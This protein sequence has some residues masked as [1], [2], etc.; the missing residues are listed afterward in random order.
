[1]NRKLYISYGSNMDRAQ[2]AVRCPDAKVV[3][4]G[5]LHNWRLFFRRYANIEPAEGKNTPV[6]VWEISGSDERRLDLYE[7][8][9]NF[10]I[11]KELE[12]ETFPAEGGMKKL[13]AMVYVMNGGYPA[14]APSS[15]YYKVL[16]D[17]YSAF[18]LPGHILR[19]ALADSIGKPQATHFLEKHGFQKAESR[20]VEPDD[21][22]SIL[23]LDS[24]FYIGMNEDGEEEVVICRQKGH[25]FSISSPTHDG[26]H[27]IAFYDENG[28]LEGVSYEK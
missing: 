6:L 27:E 25:G 3:G 21:Y 17:A 19:Q 8:F 20:Q 2:M 5:I 1:M 9:P 28:E 4:P 10:Y 12:V 13:T 11:K 18:H 26:W 15:D 22:R 14:K 24:G 16:A 7:G 23:A